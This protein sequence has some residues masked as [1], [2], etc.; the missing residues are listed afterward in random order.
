MRFTILLATTLVAALGCTSTPDDDT[1][2]QEP[3]IAY[4]KEP[5]FGA[6]AHFVPGDRAGSVA[7]SARA[8]INDAMLQQK[9]PGFDGLERP[10]V[11]VPRRAA[12]ALSWERFD[13]AYDHTIDQGATLPNA[14][15]DVY[16]TTPI[17]LSSDQLEIVVAQGVAFG[18]DSNVGTIWAQDPGRNFSV[19]DW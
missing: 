19:G 16:T 3:E 18:L 1:L 14:R 12:G 11:L 17:R 13:L 6:E 2:T 8:Q 9:H 4:R 10:F 15:E 7:I 5:A